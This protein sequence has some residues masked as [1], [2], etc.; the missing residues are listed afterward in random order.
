MAIYPTGII[1]REVTYGSAIKFIGAT[2]LTMEVTITPT[3]SLVWNGIP[4][5]NTVATVRN[6]TL[7]SEGS[8]TLP[9]TNQTGWRDDKGIVSV[10]NGAQSHYYKVSIRYL[11]TNAVEVAKREPFN[12]AVPAGDGPLDLDQLVPVTS[13]GGVTISIPDTWSQMLAAA[14]ASAAQAAAAAEAAADPKNAYDIA[15]ENGYTGTESQWLASLKGNPG[16]SAYDLAVLGGYTGTQ[17]QWFDSLRGSGA[18]PPATLAVI[19]RNKSVNYYGMDE[20]IPRARPTLTK[21]QLWRSLGFEIVR[22]PQKWNPDYTVLKA[23]LADAQ[24]VG[25]Y[26]A[27]DTHTYGHTGGVNKTQANATSLGLDAGTLIDPAIPSTVATWTDYC[28]AEYQQLGGYTSWIPLD[29]N[30]PEQA[31]EVWGPITIARR[32]ALRAAGYSG[33]LGVSSG[34]GGS[35]AAVTSSATVLTSGTYTGKVKGHPT[36]MFGPKS[37]QEDKLCFVESHLYLDGLNQNAYQTVAQL[38]AFAASQNRTNADG[39]P[40][41]TYLQYIKV[42]S[43]DGLLGSPAYTSVTKFI[44]EYSIPPIW[45][46]ADPNTLWPTTLPDVAGYTPPT[47]NDSAAD[48]D[49]KI[50][51]HQALLDVFSSKRAG[52]CMWAERDNWASA[53]RWRITDQQL[54]TISLNTGSGGGSGSVTSGGAGAKGDTGA[55]GMGVFTLNELARTQG[56]NWYGL[57]EAPGTPQHVPP[58]QA[59]LHRIKRDGITAIRL[60]VSWTVTDANLEQV[61][62][63]A[64]A[65]G[66]RVFVECHTYGHTGGTNK[67]QAAGGGGT[68]IDPA[69]QSTVDTWTAWCVSQLNKFKHHPSYVP[70]DM[71]EPSQIGSV[72]E[73]ISRQRVAALRA[74]GW[75]GLIGVSSGGGGSSAGGIN[76]ATTGHPNGWWVRDD[77]GTF[78]E[79]HLYF[80]SSVVPQT[81]WMPLNDQVVGG[82]TYQGL[83]TK[84][85]AAAV[86]GV[87]DISTYVDKKITEGF[88]GASK[89][90]ADGV[91]LRW[92]MPVF[93]GEW[94]FPPPYDPT[95]V[96]PVDG[97][98]LFPSA[99]FTEPAADKIAKLAV[100]QRILDF[101][102]SREAAACQWAYPANWSTG[103]RWKTSTEQVGQIG[104]ANR[105]TSTAAS[106]GSGF[107][108][109]GV[110]A[111][112]TA[113]AVND[114]VSNAGSTYL[115][116]TAF[117]SGT[118]FSTTNLSVWAAAGTN[119]TNGTNGAAGATGVSFPFAHN[120][121]VGNYQRSWAITGAGGSAIV[122]GNASFMPYFQARAGITYDAFG[123][124]VTTIQNS[125]GGSGTL[126]FGLYANLTNFFPD[127]T[128]IIRSGS[129]SSSAS[130]NQN[131][132]ITFT[133][134]SWTPTVDTT[135]WLSCLY[136]AGTTPPTTAP[137]LAIVN[138]AFYTIDA[139]NSIQAYNSVRGLLMSGQTVLPT[140]QVTTT[141]AVPSTSGNIVCV[142][143]R[144]SA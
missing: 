86:S 90:L 142:Y 74:A 18:F 80:D 62:S 129:I 125:G 77:P 33:V 54:I 34:G 8:I 10:A 41:T 53:Y 97:N 109:R 121:A 112:S 135:V 141:N 134:G 96:S 138:S 95:D 76:N 40:V 2:D 11:D 15:V 140:T 3:R 57:D 44:G 107:N 127:T 100:H 29:M 123:I 9:V 31:G 131:T 14:Q 143:L 116:T 87:T 50:A 75:T 23:L 28:V 133:E 39:T 65:V 59:Q 30:E 126:Y 5:I 26:I 79:F 51:W 45:D 55:A 38:D 7:G 63:D 42:K 93:V 114:V 99:P 92:P 72:W 110:W 22:V 4:V 118:T 81:N 52:S 21:L 58:T 111:A 102:K 73:N 67:T 122:T 115:V 68:L 16:L 88:F 83:N 13:T 64:D 27:T 17:T 103:Y 24:A 56:V 48:Q 60:P 124:T 101:F 139:P 43:L 78:L 119:G 35:A 49:T 25:I 20:T 47:A 98:V 104:K 120:P 137:S 108:Y 36:W 136:V 144:R 91:T 69:I 106:P 117:T 71:N 66:L 130:A 82:T 19:R 6:T 46:T 89:Y 61:L 32:N 85:V 132:P 37:A 113:Y 12:F 70:C 1:T 105:V 84:A 128:S 94:A